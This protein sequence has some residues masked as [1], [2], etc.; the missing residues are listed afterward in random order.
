MKFKIEKEYPILKIVRIF[1]AALLSSI[2]LTIDFDNIPGQYNIISTIGVVVFIVFYLYIEGKEY[3]PNKWIMIPAIGTSF[4]MLIGKSYYI[5][6]SSAMVWGSK[7]RL[8]FFFLCMIGLS[9]LFYHVYLL[10]YQGLIKLEKP[11]EISKKL[12]KIFFGKFSIIKVAGIILLT[13]LP[14][15]IYSYPGG[16]CADASYQMQQVLGRYPYDTIHPLVHTLFIG[17]FM[18]FGDIVLGSYNRGL[19]LQ[20]LVQSTIMALVMSYSIS[21]LHKRGVNRIYTLIVLCIYCFAPMYCNFA[22]MTVKDSL[23]NTWILLYFVF[24]TEMLAENAFK[25]TVKRSIQIVLSG[26]GVMLFRNNGPI[27]VGSA[28]LGLL[29]YYIIKKNINL[30]Q[31]LAMISVYCILP[32]VLFFII[33]MSLTNILDANTINGKEFLSI[34]FQQTGRYIRE[35]GYDITND[36]WEQIGK[37]LDVSQDIGAL[38]DPNISDPLK[39]AYVEDCTTADVLS[40]LLTWAKMFFKHPGVYVEAAMNHFYG[41]FDISLNNAIRYEAYLDIFY[42]PR[43]GDKTEHVNAWL[44]DLRANPLTGWLENIGVYVWWMVILTIRLL[45]SKKKEKVLIFMFPLYMSLLV[46]MASPACLLHPRYAFPIVFTIP[47]L[48]GALLR[49]K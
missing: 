38:Y 11:K 2:A 31:K 15:I 21:V 37:V 24:L 33:N 30:K 22:S 14:I 29:I 17:F 25:L 13:W 4:F 39:R 49:S 8:L 18:N 19:F 34:P 41:W 46:C 42:P 3:E 27:V 35:Y 7:V 16:Y 48:T 10:V 26:L 32:F 1:I 40:Y 28:V 44:A 43:W 12:E 23:F 45:M 20:I 5:Y 9:Y 36:E 6:N 47:F